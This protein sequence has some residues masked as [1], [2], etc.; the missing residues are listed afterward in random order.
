LSVGSND[1]LVLVPGGG[2]SHIP[3]VPCYLQV[4]VKCA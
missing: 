3:R 1:E 2:C 4:E